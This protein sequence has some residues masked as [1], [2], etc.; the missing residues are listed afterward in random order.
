[1]FFKNGKKSKYG[2]NNYAL[3][4]HSE[5]VKQFKDDYHLQSQ[6]WDISITFFNALSPLF[7]INVIIY[8][9]INI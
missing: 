2:N 8:G 1:M 5:K 4:K 9:I 7:Y 6:H 3:K